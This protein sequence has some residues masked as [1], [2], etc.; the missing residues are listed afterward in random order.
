MGRSI[1]WIHEMYGARRTARGAFLALAEDIAK[2]FDGDVA[3]PMPELDKNERSSVPNLIANGITQTA[4]R[5]ASNAPVFTFPPAR[6]HIEAS[7]KRAST[8][9]KAV[10]G[11]LAH[12]ANDFPRMME[13]RAF[14]AVG[15]GS[16]PAIV[17]PDFDLEIPVWQ[18]LSPLSV[19]PSATRNVYDVTPENAILSRT[20]PYGQLKAMYDVEFQAPGQSVP[21]VGSLRG[22]LSEDADILLLEYVDAEEDVLIAVGPD[23]LYHGHEERPVGY[24]DGRNTVRRLGPDGTDGTSRHVEL[25]LLARSPNLAGMCPVTY[26]GRVTLTGTAGQYAGSLGAHDLMARFMALEVRAVD[27]AVFPNEWVILK[28]DAQVNVMADGRKG[29]TGEIQGDAIVHVTNVNPGVMT[30]PTMDRLERAIRIDSFTAAEMGGESGTNIRTARRG[31]DV[32]SQL[33]SFP[34]QQYHRM[35]QSTLRRECR[36]AQAIALKWFGDKP[37]SFHVSWKGARGQVDYRPVDVF[38]ETDHVDVAYPMPGSDVQDTVVNASQALGV[39]GLSIDSF[40]ELLPYVDDV[41]EERRKIALDQVQRAAFGAIEQAVVSGQVALTDVIRLGV[42]IRQG[43]DPLEAF[44]QVQ[45]E[46]QER[47]ATSGPPGT[48]TGPVDPASP[49]AQPG[50]NA[51]GA[52][53]EAGTAPI[54]APA[55]GL[56]NLARLNSTL[57]LANQ[58]PGG[59]RA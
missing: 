18:P 5:A 4:L 47:A 6:P 13:F 59:G 53:G 43:T 58:S 39:G 36:V 21:G 35:F 27:A 54:G 38:T 17:R 22:Q 33:T 3:I 11:W 2:H 48:P 44:E 20:M 32:L 15:Y 24:S 56:A 1:E 50:I 49:E 8:R 40:M 31:N 55:E 45:R 7:V 19:F 30:Y 42:L 52:G 14:Q 34:L 25:I 37:Q 28:N 51:P 12:E 41:P 46:A 16:C 26:P 9:R 23:R 57:Y 10:L 29:I